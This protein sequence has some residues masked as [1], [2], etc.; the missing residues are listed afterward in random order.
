MKY[1]ENRRMLNV[2][3]GL[4][5][6]SLLLFAGCGGWGGDG[7]SPPPPP[8]PPPPPTSDSDLRAIITEKGLTGDPSIGRNL[9]SINDPLAQLGKLLFFSK[10]LSGEFD[11]ACASCHHPALAGGD[12]LSLPVG[13]GALDPDVVGPGRVT[14]DGLPNVG[15]HSPTVFNIG[16][17]DAGLFHDARIESIGKEA[18]RNGAGSGIRTPESPLGMADPDTGETLPAAQAGFPVLVPSEM[19][20]RLMPGASSDALR[21]HLASRIGDYGSGRGE[22]PDNN[23]LDA[24]QAAF[25]SG[26]PANQ[27]ITFDN[28]ALAIAEYERS[29]VFIETPWKRYVEGDNDAIPEDAKEGAILFFTDAPEGAGCG[30]CHGGDFF[31]DER[32]ATVAFPQIGPG[33]GDG[34]DADDD[35]GR[36]QQTSV[37]TDRFRFRTP[38]LLN[39]TET[40]PYS[41]AGVYV[42][43]EEVVNHYAV[44]KITFQD[45]RDAGSVCSI[46]Q[47]S[48]R[49][50]CDTLYPRMPAY[51]AAAMDKVEEERISVPGATFPDIRNL[52][53]SDVTKIQAFLRTL[54]DPCVTDRACVAP[55]IPEASEAPDGNQLNAVDVDGNPL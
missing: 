45:F 33:A 6:C 32:L 29:M 10:S 3:S 26:E 1:I 42:S 55:W 54:T 9:P 25:M 27:L 47:F 44:P 12:G 14:A 24:F 16:M 21:D 41:H 39:I 40:A 4:F 37:A 28:I 51:F 48:N 7:T 18:G 50:D 34:A 49:A 52:P 13:T 15:R 8:P 2:T 17:Y 46:P 19:R 11:T 35:Y 31:T 20:G 23:W 38:T 53:L 30:T 43:L 22:I 36:E 5:V